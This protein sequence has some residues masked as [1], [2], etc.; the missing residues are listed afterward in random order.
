MGPLKLILGTIIGTVLFLQ[1][2]SLD[3]LIRVPWIALGA[4]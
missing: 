4:L 3:N 2:L 1:L